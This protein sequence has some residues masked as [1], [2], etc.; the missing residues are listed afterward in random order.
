MIVPDNRNTGK[1]DGLRGR[2]EIADVADDL[3]GIMTALGID[4]AHIAGY[5][6]GGLAALELAHRH[7]DRVDKLIL[8][9]TSAGP[10]RSTIERVVGGIVIVVARARTV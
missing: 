9:G 5:S 8:A 7:P 1:S 4:K 10:A 3:A 6:M 2:Y